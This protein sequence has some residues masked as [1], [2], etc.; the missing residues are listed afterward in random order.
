MLTF[1]LPKSLP[2]SLYLMFSI[3]FTMSASKGKAHMIA[4]EKSSLFV[5]S[6][7]DIPSC[8]YSCKGEKGDSKR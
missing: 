3:L 5:A 7:S 4:M 6:R 1:A 2:R 8:V